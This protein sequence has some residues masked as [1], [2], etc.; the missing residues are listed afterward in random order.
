[1]SVDEQVITALR[2]EL[3][4]LEVSPG[5]PAVALTQGSRLR[6]RRTTTRVV[7]GV[8]AVSVVAALGAFLSGGERGLQPA[9]A[10]VG[11]WTELPP[12]PLSPRTGSVAVWTGGKAIFLGGQTEAFCPPNAD[13]AATP[14]F[15][16]D[17]AAYDPSTKKWAAIAQAPGAVAYYTPHVLVDGLLV[18]VDVQDA[19]H[20]YD[21]EE[22][23]WQSL[24]DPPTRVEIYSESLSATDGSVYTLGQGGSVLVLDVAAKTW[25]TL[26][27]SPNQP[28]LEHSVLQATPEGI[29]KIGVD[30]TARNDGTEPSYLIA[31]VYRDGAWQRSERSDIMGGY[32][33]H[34][35]GERLVSPTPTCVDG[36]EV[37]PFPRCIP[38]GGTFD[39][40]SGAW[41]TLPPAPENDATGD[42]S[43]HADAGPWMLSYGFVYDDAEGSWSRL[44][45]PEG[46]S[47][48][49]DVS[50]VVN[51]DAVIAFGGVDW[52]GGV[53]DGHA[54]NQAWQ[55]SR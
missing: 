25:S 37:N 32:T 42:W 54:T 49:M 44:G 45:T 41:G 8:A 6:R 18:I 7:A 20:V 27:P 3:E 33:W 14:T 52:S 12:A 10:P 22:D 50:S 40:A 55:W 51:E 53:S 17:G 4:H 24:P 43:L 2:G 38:E 16:R 39:P 9:P 11:D 23:A 26:P 29:V 28:R 35:T 47:E 15:A 46:L 1:M 30:S 13:C 36:G 21:P 5:D 34:W 19:W 48:L 31:D